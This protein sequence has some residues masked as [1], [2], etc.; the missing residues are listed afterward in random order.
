ME[1]GRV[2]WRAIFFYLL[3]DMLGRDPEPLRDIALVLPELLHHTSLLIDPAQ[4]GDGNAALSAPLR[5]VTEHP[6]LPAE[7]KRGVCEALQTAFSR[8]QAGQSLDLRWSRNLNPTQLDVWMADS[9]GAKILQMY[10]LRTA[11][12]IEGMADA[13]V[14]LAGSDEN[15]RHAV[16]RFARSFGL[17]FQL[18]DDVENFTGAPVGDDSTGSD[19]RNGK[20][21]Y[22]IF[23]ALKR[24]APPERSVLRDIL[25]QSDLRCDANALNRGIDLIVGSGA[26]ARVSAEARTYVAPAWEALSRIVPASSSKTELRFLWESLLASSL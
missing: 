3:L 1:R 23:R 9:F 26:C 12:L 22:L 16:L 21:T 19:L 15:T 24:L 6:T 4:D 7:H 5:L 2:R 8:I 10:A 17:A 18:L 13:A 11:S 14:L 20:L 25:C